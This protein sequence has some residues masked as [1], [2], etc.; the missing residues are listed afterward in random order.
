MLSGQ[1]DQAA[2][3]F[4]RVLVLDPDHTGALTNLGLT[5]LELDRPAE[6]EAA[7]RRLVA[8]APDDP[9]AHYNLACGLSRGW[10]TSGAAS[11]LGRQRDDDGP[12]LVYVPE[13]G[14]S[15]DTFVA[16]VAAVHKDLHRCVV[17]VSE[18]IADVDGETWAEKLAENAEHDAHGN[19]QL[20][21]TGALADFLSGQIK[22]KLSIDRVRAD[23]FGY[24]QRSFAGLQSS[25]DA[26]EARECG[27]QAVK[28]SMAYESGSV[29]M[30]RTGDGADYGVRYER[31]DLCNV[32]EKT[33]EMPRAFINTQ[34]NHVTE[35]FVKYALPLTG[36]LVKTDYLGNR[37][38]V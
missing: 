4:E 7:L 36:G 21:G 6:A 3:A 15:M 2:L 31:T 5:L 38:R 18:G 14:V 9:L 11:A 30:I 10:N 27:R 23:T 25:V 26:A 13:C 8:V 29:A 19:I 37:P 20:S 33:K 1:P 22:E 35:A 32:A 16:D 12:H 24:L 28:M 34:G 17:A